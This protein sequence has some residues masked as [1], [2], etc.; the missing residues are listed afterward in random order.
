MFAAD[1]NLIAVLV[2]VVVKFAIGAVWYAPPVFGTRWQELIGQTPERMKERMGRAMVTDLLMSLV[3]AVVLAHALR[4][5]GQQDLLGGAAAGFLA[6]LGFVA[7]PMRAA[8]V[9]EDRSI[10]LFTINVTY[11]LVSLVVMGAILGAMS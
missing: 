3:T 11:L 7:A 2:A 6:W 5:T 8:F 10:M 1:I 4:I 9:Y